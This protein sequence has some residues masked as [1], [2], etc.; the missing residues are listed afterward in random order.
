M[1][2]RSPFYHAKIIRGA[3]TLTQ[4]PLQVNA[5]LLCFRL[6][7]M[8]EINNTPAYSYKRYGKNGIT[9]VNHH[10]EIT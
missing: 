7:F 4:L 3:F 9:E 2:S 6:V 8:V 5:D 1:Q 10:V